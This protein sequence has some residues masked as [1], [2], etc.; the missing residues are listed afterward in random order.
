MINYPLIS[1]A[2]ATHNGEKYLKEQLDSIYAQTYKNIEV[3]VTDDCSADRTV[4]V[5]EQYSKSHGLQYF[6]NEENMGYV[7]NFEKAISLCTG[8]FIA[9]CDQDDVWRP[10]KLEKLYK[11]I[12]SNLLIHSDAKLID[13]DGNIFSESYT[14]KAHK[15][16][17]KNT[18]EYFFSNDVT[19]C[20][21][22]FKKELLAFALPFPE[23]MLAHDWWLAICASKE[24]S[25]KYFN[26]P[27]ISYRQHTSNQI[28]AADVSKIYPHTLR[29]RAY[30]KTLLFLQSLY[31][32]KNWNDKEKKAIEDLIRYHRAYFSNTVRIGSFFIHLKYL[33][34]FYSDKSTMYRF[35]GLLLSL[36]GKSIQEKLWR[37]INK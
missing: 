16:F 14:N 25:I 6:V 35:F 5:L 20:T 26:E 18:Y 32:A 24:G 23:G 37:I 11:N 28:G 29:V 9:L 2:M 3:I 10:D 22:L 34:L 19:G 1:I 15:K 36:F 7:K 13:E 17:R 21:T 8:E 31:N 12:G 30:Q 27:L 33:N 4:E